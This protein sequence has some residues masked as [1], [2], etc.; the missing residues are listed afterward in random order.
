MKLEGLADGVSAP[1]QP[2][3]KSSII[4][5]KDDDDD[6]AVNFPSHLAPLLVLVQQ[7]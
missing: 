7:R 2:A 1:T 3:G 6:D 5:S 4:A